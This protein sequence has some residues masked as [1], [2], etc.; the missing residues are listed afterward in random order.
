MNRRSTFVLAVAISGASLAAFPHSAT[1]VQ[2]RNLEVQIRANRDRLEE[3]RRERESLQSDLDALRGRAR[4]ITSELQNIDKQRTATVR[5]VREL[6]RQISGLST[7]LDTISFEMTLAEDALSEKDAVLK[8]RVA[9]IY[10][11]GPLWGF[12][13]LLAAES[14]G[15]LLSRYKYLYLVSRQDRQIVQEIQTLRDQVSQQRSD[16]VNLRNEVAVQRRERDNELQEFASL[17]HQRVRAL[18]TMRATESRTSNRIDSLTRDEERI[19]EAIAALERARRASGDAVAPSISAVDMGTLPWPVEGEVIYR[20]GVEGFRDRTRL[21]N[22]GIGI[23]VPPGT[24]VRVVRSGKVVSTSAYGT[25]GPSVWVSHGD[26]FYTL[27]LYLSRVAVRLNQI[28]QEGDIIG[29]S[30]GENSD[31]GPHLEFQLR[32]TPPN[33]E[34]PIP[35]DPLD[36]LQPRG[37]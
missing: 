6:D 10:K 29:L 37:R 18:A 22:Q 16:L 5:L 20:V 8:Q 27:Y 13:V 24:P 25:Y 9:E 26:G 19:N 12:Q 2:R 23:R 34:T 17:E 1:G 32:Q 30:G 4:S 31:H 35:L 21:S 33:A 36:W 7:Q 28:V 3:I 11:R 14:F 15:D